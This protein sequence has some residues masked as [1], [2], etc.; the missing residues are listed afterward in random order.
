M[1]GFIAFGGARTTPRH[2]EGV[3]APV[4][5]WAPLG[6][7]V[8]LA[9][10]LAALAS[11]LGTW[12]QNV[13]AAWLMTSLSNSPL[14]IALIQTASSLPI[15][16]LALPGGALAD[17]VDRRRLLI[18]SQVWMLI[19]AG[20]LGVLTFLGMTTEWTLLGLSFMLGIG[21]ALN[22][23]A[24]QAIVTELVPREE[25]A[26]AVTLNGINFNLARAVG[27]ALGGLVVAL[28]GAG[29][30]FLLNAASFMGVMIVLYNWRRRQYHC[31]LPAE[32]VIGAIRVGLRYVRYAPPLR[33]VL[34]RTVAFVLGAS[35]TWAAL[36]VIARWQL[37]L[38]AGG[39]GLLLGCFGFGAVIGGSMLT[40]IQQ[41]VSHDNI[42]HGATILFAA[43]TVGL[44]FAR[45]SITASLLLALGGSAWVCAFSV[46]NVAAQLSV[47]QWVQGRAL[48][49]YQ[50]AIQ[51]G[52]AGAS[53]L[54][55]AV[56]ARW[57]LQ[58]AL[59]CG[60][61]SLLAGLLTY[62]W[63]LAIADE[64]KTDPVDL[65][66]HP[67]IAIDL[68]PNSGPALITV[69][70]RIDPARSKE[71]IEVMRHQRMTRLRDGAVFWGLFVDANQPDRFVEQ[72]I[73]ETWLEHL[74]Q[75]E[76]LIASDALYES[77][78]KSF[79]LGD[80]L[81][82]THMISADVVVG[83]DLGSFKRVNS[84]AGGVIEPEPG[85]NKTPS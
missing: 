10:W 48:A 28:F 56:G 68:N 7:R 43:I 64:I 5:A 4:S 21:N 83:H 17:I 23:P 37:H 41:R 51:G 77:R 1:G 9:L 47:P 73:N 72:F 12:M 8:F 6:R 79:N 57:G 61:L 58:I 26:A 54:W 82:I 59:G 81:H 69:E 40:R 25:L 33:A 24:W 85:I 71:F 76:R 46:L 32:R 29:A 75:H 19:A 13:G 27:P 67:H 20:A 15:F 66:P 53:A 2:Q 63:R 16:F 42:V 70:Y 38:G 49:V 31:V 30:N 34:V 78:A 14:T 18:F 44:V 80:T 50:I 11:N 55:G 65:W 22:A 74:R 52:L 84:T 36:P 3:A 35:A 39:F 60:A 45:D 62:S